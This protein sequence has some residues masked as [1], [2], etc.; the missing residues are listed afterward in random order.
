MSRHLLTFSAAAAP[1]VL[2]IR[3][4]H[5][6]S[7]ETKPNGDNNR[8]YKIERVQRSFARSFVVPRDVDA[9]KIEAQIN[10][11]VLSVTIPKV[12]LFMDLP[13][14]SN[15]EHGILCCCV[16]CQNVPLTLSFA[17]PLLI[18][19][20]GRGHCQEARAPQDRCP[21]DRLGC[22]RAAGGEMCLHQM[23]NS[24]EIFVSLHEVDFSCI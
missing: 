24:H 1:Q 5:T 13:H 17:P 19:L 8:M 21:D 22:C 18:M 20:K 7:K 15:T 3:G 14:A 9:N 6:E 16:N 4:E 23:M 12:G 2:T 10:N 11:G